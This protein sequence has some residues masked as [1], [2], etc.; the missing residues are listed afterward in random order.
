[1]KLSAAL[2]GSRNG[3]KMIS[4]NN[5][6]QLEQGQIQQASVGCK[7]SQQ[8]KLTSSASKTIKRSSYLHARV[9][10]FLLYNLPKRDK[11]YRMTKIYQMAIYILYQ[12]A[13]YILYQM[14]M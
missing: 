6:V 3:R 1:M 13:I 11:I 8:F 9:A 10:R 12:M 2:I 4:D 5:P 14:A 7:F